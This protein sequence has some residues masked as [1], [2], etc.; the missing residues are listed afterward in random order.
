VVSSSFT[1]T[2]TLTTI[3][4]VG[5]TTLPN[6][7]QSSYVTLVTSSIAP[8]GSLN[9]SQNG[10]KS[11]SGSGRAVAI[12]AGV[13]GGIIAL[14]ILMFGITWHI[15]RKRK[16]AFDDLN[17][18]EIWGP[19]HEA[20]ALQSSVNSSV[21]G[22]GYTYNPYGEPRSIAYAPV[23]SMSPPRP[24]S[25]PLADPDD[26]GLPGAGYGVPQG[27]GLGVAAPLLTR[28]KTADEILYEAAREGLPRSRTSSATAS[29][30]TRPSETGTS[31][32]P[33]P[34]LSASNLTHGSMKSRRSESV[35]GL[36][37][38][39]AI[40]SARTSLYHD[41]QVAQQYHDLI[42]VPDRPMSP[43]SVVAP[44]LAIVN[45]DEDKDL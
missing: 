11:G 31:H 24:M 27:G 30:H 16:N 8:N 29:H 32:Q 41:A 9:D 33:H 12:G 10:G 34:S 13:T 22:P 18:S 25:M 45:P 37:E 28:A 14:I 21:H 26:R 7:S 1:E 36:L 19:N 20:K 44:R 42:D 23:P 35:V 4:S 17:N 38:H 2:G 43:V 3:T 15:R 39:P 6:G 5:S 40:P